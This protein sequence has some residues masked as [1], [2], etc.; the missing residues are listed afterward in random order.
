MVRRIIN[1]FNKD[2]GGLHEAAYL[3]GAFAL[4]SQILALFSR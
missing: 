3:L 4:V 1:L 2:F